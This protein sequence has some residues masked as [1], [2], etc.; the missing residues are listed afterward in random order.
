M[1]LSCATA[2]PQDAPSSDT[3]TKALPGQPTYDEQ[4]VY[5]EQA[6]EFVQQALEAT[7]LCA[8]ANLFSQAVEAAPKTK[9]G[10][11]AA[12]HLKRI[13][14]KFAQAERSAVATYAKMAKAR[15]SQDELTNFAAQISAG[16]Y[17]CEYKPAVERMEQAL[18][19]A[20]KKYPAWNV[21]Y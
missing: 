17:E 11:L 18:D 10:K 7:S 3:Y 1:C 6:K 4:D 20:A 15:Y 14:A 16:I 21:T 9:D 12:S 2:K 13:N 8:K 19:K 5:D